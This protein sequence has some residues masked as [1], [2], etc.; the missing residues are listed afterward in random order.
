MS[1]AAR[2]GQSAHLAAALPAVL[3]ALPRF[4]PSQRWYGG[5]ERAGRA[6]R[7]PRHGARFLSI[8][9]TLLAMVDVSQRRPGA[10]QLLPAAR[11]PASRWLAGARR[12]HR[13]AG[14]LTV[15][16]AIADPETCRA[17]LRGIAERRLLATARGGAF[18]FQPGQVTQWRRISSGGGPR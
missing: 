10:R 7:D 9:G 3:A 5:K 17:L 13:A 8:R 16:D 12:G 2:D 1:G 15:R 6:R 4:L 11:H 14:D 18:E